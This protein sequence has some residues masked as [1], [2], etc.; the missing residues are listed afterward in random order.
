MCR[1]YF[2]CPQFH[3]ERL[4]PEAYQQSK[5]LQEHW[6]PAITIPTELHRSGTRG[7]CYDT[8]T[9]LWGYDD[10]YYSNPKLLGM[11]ETI[12]SALILYRLICVF[13]LAIHT[14][15]PEG[16]RT[17]WRMAMRHQGT[18][19]VVVFHDDKGAWTFGHVAAKLPEEFRRDLLTLLNHVV[20]SCPHPYGS[21]VAGSVG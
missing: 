16:Y 3:A 7:L 10:S 11:A 15:G 4:K 19:E 20:G 8:E 21:V 12:S 6:A 17:V 2:V 13:R 9:N 5:L 1:N 18:G 14:P